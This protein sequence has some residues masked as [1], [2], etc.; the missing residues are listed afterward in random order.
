MYYLDYSIWN[1]DE[2]N[3]L[4]YSIFLVMDFMNELD[5]WPT[6]S[7]TKYIDICNESCNESNTIESS[8]KSFRV[9]EHRRL[10]LR[11]HR[12]PQKQNGTDGKETALL[13]LYYGVSSVY[14]KTEQLAYI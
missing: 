2:F 10:I 5:M 12:E 13:L 11:M 8:F 9:D 3:H 4:S 1:V 14:L 6:S 7:F